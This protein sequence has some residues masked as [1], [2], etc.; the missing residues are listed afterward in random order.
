[1]ENVLKEHAWMCPKCDSWI[2]NSIDRDY[3][4]NTMHPD[5]SNPF[6]QAWWARG[7]PGMSPY[8]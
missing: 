2:S 1:M 5:F 8:D 6:V 4:E 3:H 7:R